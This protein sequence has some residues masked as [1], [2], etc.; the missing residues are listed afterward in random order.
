MLDQSKKEFPK[1]QVKDFPNYSYSPMKKPTQGQN[2]IAKNQMFAVQ[3]HDSDDMEINICQNDIDDSTMKLQQKTR[4]G[5]RRAA[6]N[7]NKG[8]GAS[9]VKA[10]FAMPNHPL[11]P[12]KIKEV[13]GLDQ[14]F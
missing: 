3:Q 6:L 7:R 12:S 14:R 2:F 9:G 10:N 8:S 13:N 1:M 5:R 4:D 11:N